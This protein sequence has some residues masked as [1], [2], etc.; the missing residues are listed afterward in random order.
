MAKQNNKNNQGD[1]KTPETISYDS[2]KEK[3]PEK[4]IPEKPQ[5]EV[6]KPPA[7][8]VATN[9]AKPYKDKSGNFW[10]NGVQKFYLIKKG[11]SQIERGGKL[12][13]EDT[14]IECP[15]YENLLPG[16]VKIKKE[17]GEIFK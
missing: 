1:S 2:T 11:K 5:V 8:E 6:S 4:V 3:A 14:G 16:D 13:F 15:Y 10:E 17:K 12:V 7:E 9:F